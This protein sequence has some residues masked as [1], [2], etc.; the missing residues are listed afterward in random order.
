MKTTSDATSRYRRIFVAIALL[1]IL[2][3]IVAACIGWRWYSTKQQRE[4]LQAHRAAVIDVSIQVVTAAMSF[5]HRDPEE[6]F[7][8]LKSISTGGFLAEQGEWRDDIV[9][10]VSAQK[11]VT[12]ATVNNVAVSE[13]S[14]GDAK[15]VVVYTA[16]S[17]REG[18]QGITI[19]QA[20]R[21]G[22]EQVDGVWLV[23]SL[24]PLGVPVPV[25]DSSASVRSLTPEN[26]TSES[27]QDT[28]ASET[29]QQ[30]TPSGR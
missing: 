14:G 6:S 27:P 26:Q 21:V 10:Q 9:A 4:D 5:D 17:R 25:G 3:A 24:L 11:A 30:E 18:K 28:A 19:R 2:A 13:L 8:E 7:T 22:L 15:A 29:S 12:E 16:R 1:T 20:A 23:N